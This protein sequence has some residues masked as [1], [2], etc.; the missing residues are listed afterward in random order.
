MIH[1][2]SDEDPQLGD[3]GAVTPLANPK[4]TADAIR[5]LLT[6]GEVYERCSRTAQTRVRKYYNKATLDRAYRE[7]YETHM[8]MVDSLVGV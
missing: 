3:A 6:D 5:R 1:G 8:A 2:R 4:A 7:I